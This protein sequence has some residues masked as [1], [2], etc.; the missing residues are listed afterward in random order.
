MKPQAMMHA[1][2]FTLIEVLVALSIVAITLGAGLQTTNA[3]INWSERQRM[4]M[5][6]QLCAENALIHIRLQSQRP[7]LGRAQSS[8]TQA[9]QTMSVL[10]ETQPTP[11]PLFSRVKVSVQVPLS[12]A[13]EPV[14]LM[15]LMTIVGKF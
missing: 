2:G 11:N 9:D 5:L 14:T 13:S 1:K 8:C 10:T 6:A 12:D 7:A 4:Q 15:Q 3:L